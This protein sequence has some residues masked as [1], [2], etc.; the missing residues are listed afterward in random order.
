MGGQLSP[1]LARRG[2]A[3]SSSLSLPRRYSGE[4]L[5]LSRKDDKMSTSGKVKITV[6]KREE[7]SPKHAN[8]EMKNERNISE[9]QV[10]PETLQNNHGNKL[11]PQ[12]PRTPK[13]QL[14]N[15][16]IAKSAT[17][18]KKLVSLDAVS[19]ISDYSILS[20]VEFASRKT[21]TEKKRHQE[22]T[23]PLTFKSLKDFTNSPEGKA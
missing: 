3:I 13:Q 14:P 16:Q 12:R 11:L 4:S 7:L 9:I 17:T 6:E 8:V 23:S 1:S 21:A 18:N 2:S 15:T 19:C 20:N 22:G 5:A 10:F